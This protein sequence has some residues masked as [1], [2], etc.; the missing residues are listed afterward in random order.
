MDQTNE[1]GNYQ[2]GNPANPVEASQNWSERNACDQRNNLG[3]PLFQVKLIFLVFCQ[4]L[5]E[6]TETL[7]LKYAYQGPKMN[8]EENQIRKQILEGKEK[9]QKKMCEP[10]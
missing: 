8:G 5:A 6:P 1:K 9:F 10:N 7:N 4:L 2:N 3:K